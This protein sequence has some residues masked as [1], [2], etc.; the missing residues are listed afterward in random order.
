MR[1]SVVVPCFNHGRFLPDCLESLAVQ[2]VAPAEVI[3]VND[4]STDP[5]TEAIC[6]RL[7]DYH[8]PFP[9]K[10]V[11][12]ANQGVAAAR[13]RGIRA[14]TGD[15]ILPLDADDKLLPHA[16]AA[17]QAAFDLRPAIDIFS[18]DMAAFGAKSFTYLTPELNRWRLLH[19]NTMVCSSAIRRRVFDS[20]YWYDETLRHAEDWEF[21]MRVCALGP[22][23]AAPLR[24]LVFAYRKWGHSLSSGIER[25]EVL[26]A[27][28]SRHARAGL[29]SPTIDRILRTRHAPTHRIVGD[30]QSGPAIDD[31]GFV[32]EA[33]LGSFLRADPISRFLWFGAV[34]PEA[35][36]CLQQLVNEWSSCRVPAHLAFVDAASQS[37]YA[38]VLD[39]CA[40]LEGAT[41]A[42][43]PL[44]FTCLTTAGYRFPRLVSVGE[45][46]PLADSVAELLEPWRRLGYPSLLPPEQSQDERLCADIHY[47]LHREP[48]VPAPLIPATAERT[49]VVVLS[50]ISEGAA[51]RDLES[52]LAAP[53][54]RARFDGVLVVAFD[55]GD[56]A[57]YDRIALRCD[58]LVDLGSPRRDTE[59]QLAVALGA[60]V[61]SRAGT[62]LIIGALEGF[63]LAQ[64]IRQARLPLWVTVQLH[65][66]SGDDAVRQ[67]AMHHAAVVDRVVC[68]VDH[69]TRLV[70]DLYFPRH[71]VR[72][73]AAAADAVDRHE[74][75]GRSLPLDQ[76]A[77]TESGPFTDAIV[78]WLFPEDATRRTDPL[79]LRHGVSVADPQYPVRHAPGRPKPHDDLDPT[80]IDQSSRAV[81]T[82]ARPSPLVQQLAEVRRLNRRLELAN[83]E[84]LERNRQLGAALSRH[85]AKAV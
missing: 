50:R 13:N 16:I 38:V 24:A 61:A 46:L 19:F 43:A 37:P 9:V 76:P 32:R 2:E 59:R 1:F 64:R 82:A 42:A 85:R 40:A 15:V 74:N 78:A 73:P 25:D 23:T 29:W 12:Q 53:A 81:P 66:T 36:P 5:E 83:S 55:G 65:S 3:V 77:A 31:C 6:R 17:Y 48:E 51:T 30:T 39:R 80:A 26:A 70:D 41:S 27:I 11:H 56:P 33:E 21:Y 4:G 44:R 60:V 62:L 84:L 69:S 52:L 14:A 10:V 49:L 63:E 57:A 71:K 72:A 68:P 75:R 58:G 28:R 8:Y 34:G 7:I 20:G 79:D 18:P 22:F 67:L 47:Y 35:Q 54:L 45:P